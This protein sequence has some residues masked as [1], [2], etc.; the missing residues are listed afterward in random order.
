MQQRSCLYDKM[1]V[2][3]RRCTY[4]RSKSNLRKQTICIKN[5]YPSFN[6]RELDSGCGIGIVSG[7]GNLYS[8]AGT[9]RLRL[10]DSRGNILFDYIFIHMTMSTHLSSC[11]FC[12]GYKST[13]NF[14]TLNQLKPIIPTATSYHC[15]FSFHF[16]TFDPFRLDFHS[17]IIQ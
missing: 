12:F 1:P 16:V 7:S 10:C 11:Y 6:K 4:T 8:K 17:P 3:W 14:T 13:S 9:G 5:A 15:I 2:L